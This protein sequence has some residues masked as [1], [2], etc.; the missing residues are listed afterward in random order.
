MLPRFIA[1]ATCAALQ[2][3]PLTA[4]GQQ[5]EAEEDTVHVY[6]LDAIMVEGRADDLAGLVS[7]ASTGFVG[8]SDLR[9]RPIAR[10]GELLEVVPGMIL[11][12]HSGSG[13][14][15]QQFVRGFNLDHGTDFSTRVEGMPVN[16]STHAHGQ[17]YTDLNFLI[18]EL[19][20]SIEYSLGNYYAEIGDF[21]S[22]GGAH[23]RLT[24]EL[25]RPVFKT[26]VGANGHRRL[27]A[28]G[29]VSLGSR[30]S[31]LVG[32]EL[33]SY[34]G[35]WEIPEDS[36]K[37]SAMARYLFQGTTH[38]FSLLALGYGN[39]WQASD[40]IPRRA[41]ES[42]RVDRFGQI[43]P[44]LGGTTS[45]FSVSG[46]WERSSGST[47]QQ[48]DLYA[49]R[50]DL[51]LFSNFTYFLENPEE[52]DQIRQVDDG[53]WT[54]GANA[55]HQ[56]PLD[57]FGRAGDLSLGVQL[58]SDASDLTLA[59]SRARIP[60]GDI[61]ADAVRQGSAG[62]YAE[63]TTRWSP[64]VRTIVGLRG[65]LFAFDVE[66]D[67]QQNSGTATDGIVSPKVSIAWMP[68]PGLELYGSGGLGFHSNDARGVVASL[69]PVT[70]EA[71]SPV[72]PLVAS[73]G[74]EVGAR[75]ATASGLVTTAALWLVH[76]DSELVYVGD[77]GRVEASDPS[78]R[79]G[80]TITN[81][82][83][84]DA[85]W[86]A[87]LD[88]SFTRARLVVDDAD[89]DRIPGAVEQVITAGLAYDPPGNG[90]FGALRLRQMGAYPLTPDGAEK[91]RP[92]SLLNFE[93]G[94]S[95][96]DVRLSAQVLN[97]LDEKDSDIQYFYA[98]RLAGEP[99][100]GIEDL[101]FHPS[102]PRQLRVSLGW[103]F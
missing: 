42:G 102:E 28:G 86:T 92:S 37:T 100:G 29:S 35:P 64:T 80:L 15:N 98:S 33:R 90:P 57:H 101:H 72:D 95:I 91:A 12:Q 22:A 8:A 71:V 63:L 21:G 23:F 85:G 53:R 96:G 58:R 20:E 50:Y 68:R 41:V 61:R 87:D 55:V 45:R 2:L 81:F 52:G 89:S 67:L 93:I 5:T 38:T 62:A 84:L 70:G 18:P 43:D 46:T 69:D 75:M 83:R 36:R 3:L 77:A 25:E 31:V 51:D 56:Q 78:R 13:K 79:L 34:D 17:G 66:S 30:S 97:L 88:I 40:Q 24:R 16:L 10:E 76:L 4:A 47:S 73:Q 11:T 74:A 39:R 103:G 94:A 9:M 65:D 27:M 99:P 19:V 59:R 7:S 49:V 32:G 54:V 48:V 6:T 14:A 82:Y 44:T 60:L 1:A 26:G